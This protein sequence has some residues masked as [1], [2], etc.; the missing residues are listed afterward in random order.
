[1]TSLVE[2]GSAVGLGYAHYFADVMGATFLWVMM[3]STWE[4]VS[5]S[6]RVVDGRD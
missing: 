5:A 4:T 3:E 2:I 1:M 6:L